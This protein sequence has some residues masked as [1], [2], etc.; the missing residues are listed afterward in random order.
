VFFE[1]ALDPV[2]RP[3]EHDR[4]TH[5]EAFRSGVETCA[6]KENRREVEAAGR[7]IIDTKK[8]APDMGAEDWCSGNRGAVI[9]VVKAGNPSANAADFI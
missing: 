5:A 4:G 7:A 2:R 3:S 1:R 9:L 6:R 8:K